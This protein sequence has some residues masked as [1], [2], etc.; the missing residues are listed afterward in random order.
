MLLCLPCIKISWHGNCTV[1]FSSNFL[2]HVFAGKGTFMHVLT[3]EMIINMQRFSNS[4]NLEQLEQFLDII[5]DYNRLLTLSN[6]DTQKA[7]QLFQKSLAV[8]T[9]D[10]ESTFTTVVAKSN[11]PV[12][13]NVV[14]LKH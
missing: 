10:E 4:L 14:A 1:I 7:Y 13:G 12:S 2:A 5:D 3:N 9:P 11:Q 8:K 6:Q